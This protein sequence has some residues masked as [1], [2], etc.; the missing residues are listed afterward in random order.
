MTQNTGGKD[1]LRSIYQYLT[2][3]SDNGEKSLYIATH[4]RRSYAERVANYLREGK[5]VK[6]TVLSFENGTFK[7]VSFAYD[8][9]VEDRTEKWALGT[10][11]FIQVPTLT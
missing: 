9:V 6:L 1:N 5:N 10:E 8:F 4:A 7:S 2:Y 3:I 11:R